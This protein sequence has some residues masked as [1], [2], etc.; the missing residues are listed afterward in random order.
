MTDDDFLVVPPDPFD[1]PLPPR[2]PRAEP[3]TAPTDPP[4]D[5]PRREPKQRYVNNVHARKRR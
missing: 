5:P 2:P 4:P 3:P 1:S